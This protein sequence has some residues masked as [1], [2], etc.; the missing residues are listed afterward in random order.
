MEDAFGK[1]EVIETRGETLRGVVG[2]E[3]G[4]RGRRLRSMG[5]RFFDRSE[6]R[7]L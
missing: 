2:V 4:G 7:F 3:E 6:E 5:R 1:A